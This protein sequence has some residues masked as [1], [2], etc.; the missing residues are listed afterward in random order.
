[1]ANKVWPQNFYNNN[2]GSFYATLRTCLHG[3]KGVDHGNSIRITKTPFYTT[4]VKD[5]SECKYMIGTR[6]VDPESGLTYKTTEIKGAP[7]KDITAW[8][9]RVYNGKLDKNSQGLFYVKDILLYT[10]P[11]LMRR[12]T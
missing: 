7:K 3:K 10:Q 2:Q 9:K 5:V 11:T 8:Q 6:H 12:Y 4:P 1:M